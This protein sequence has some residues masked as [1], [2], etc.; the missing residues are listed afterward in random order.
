[1]KKTSK[2]QLTA[3]VL[4]DHK[5]YGQAVPARATY[6]VIHKNALFYFSQVY[7]LIKTTYTQVAK[8]NQNDVPRKIGIT[9]HEPRIAHVV[10]YR[11]VCLELPVAA[12]VYL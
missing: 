12:V 11:K 10:K 1:M 7:N 4:D 9:L 8:L 5:K 6:M 2:N 3:V